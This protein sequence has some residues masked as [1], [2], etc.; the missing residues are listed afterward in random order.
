MRCDRIGES[1]AIKLHQ[2]RIHGPSEADF[3]IASLPKRTQV[4]LARLMAFDNSE[5]WLAKSDDLTDGN[6]TGVAIKSST[7]T[8]TTCCVYEP[9]DA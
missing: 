2:E 4:F 9:V 6:L 5:I 3:Q 1:D 7:A 8:S